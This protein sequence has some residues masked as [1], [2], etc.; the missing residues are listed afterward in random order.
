MDGPRGKYATQYYK[1]S[2]TLGLRRSKK[3]GGKQIGCFGGRKTAFDEVA[4]RK[5]GNDLKK[6]LDEGEIDEETA[7][8]FGK[9]LCAKFPK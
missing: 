3:D 8:A 6:Q 7:I 1:A 9:D 2:N 4:L 5:I